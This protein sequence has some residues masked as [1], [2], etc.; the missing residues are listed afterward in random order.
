MKS[1]FLLLFLTSSPDLNY[2][3]YSNP[4]YDKLVGDSDFIRDPAL[5]LQ[6]LAKAEQIL[7][8][9]VG[10]IPLYNDVTR[11]MVSPQV[12]GWI[13]NPA[14]FNRSRWLSLNRAVVTI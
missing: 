4:Q 13:P 7:L 12:V 1:T 8:D 11:D 3:S 14:N 2:G 10:V 6:T 9:D 5:R